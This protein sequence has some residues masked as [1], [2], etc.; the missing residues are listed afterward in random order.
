M[1]SVTEDHTTEQRNIPC[2]RNSTVEKMTFATISTTKMSCLR[3]CAR[4]SDCEPRA[5][6]CRLSTR[7]CS[8]NGVETGRGIS[9]VIR[10][11]ITFQYADK[12]RCP[13]LPKITGWRCRGNTLLKR[14]HVKTLWWRVASRGENTPSKGLL[15]THC[16]IIKACVELRGGL[17]L[18]PTTSWTLWRSTLVS[19]VS[20]AQ[21]LVTRRCE[22]QSEKQFE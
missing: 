7:T 13:F 15:D 20:C 5:R 14:S 19:F 22:R 11:W 6:R 16:Q 18:E 2:R 1:V 8:S 3:T 9:A 10:H 21:M 17:S 12:W 4:T